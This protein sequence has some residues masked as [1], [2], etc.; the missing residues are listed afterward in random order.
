[1][2][3]VLITK[4]PPGKSVLPHIDHGW[5]ARAHCKVALQIKAHEMQRFCFETKQISTMP[6]DVFWFDNSFVHW[7]E[8]PSPVERVTM[9]VCI[10]RRH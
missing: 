6:G 10:Q 8:N 9:I 7:V 2:G 5:H 1:M 3:G 4:I